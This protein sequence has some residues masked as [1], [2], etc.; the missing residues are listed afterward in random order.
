MR[1]QKRDPGK[2]KKKID[3][4]SFVISL[5]LSQPQPLTLSLPLT[6]TSL[7]RPFLLLKNS[8]S[9]APATTR[10]ALIPP[11]GDGPALVDLMLKDDAAKAAA[12][13]RATKT[14]ELSDRGACDVELLIVGGFSPLQGFMDEREYTAVVQT[15]RLPDG[16][17][18]GLPVVLDTNDDAIKEG[19]ALLLTYKGQELAVLDVSSKWTPNKPVEARQCYGTTSIEHPAVQMITMERGRYYLGGK[20]SGLALPKRAFPCASPAEVRAGLPVGEDVLAFQCRNPIHRAHY[21]LFTRALDASNV[22]KGAVCLVHPTVGPTQDDDIPGE[23]RV[24]TYEVLKEEVGNPRLRWA[25]LPYSMHMAGPR[26]AVQHMAIRKNY[27]CTH[28]IIGRDMAGCKSSL[29]GEKRKKKLLLFRISKVGFFFLSSFFSSHLQKIPIL[30]K[31]KLKNQPRRRLLHPLRGPG[32]G[33]PR[34]PGAR[35]GHR[36]LS[37]H[38]LHR[39]EGLRD[40]RRRRKRKPPPAEAVRDQV[41][42]AAAVRGGDPGVV[43]VQVGGQGAE[44]DLREEERGMR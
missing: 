37:Q 44:G 12:K 8:A 26:E 25:Y 10:T 17:L 40:G 34:R 30:E 43:C 2:K 4:A 28:F 6:S 15:M 42:A 9:A 32:H 3:D 14:V 19:D 11:H 18:F 21:E 33:P 36:P 7:N 31:Q 23:A 20:I 24:R 38:H 1:V 16:L 29:S 13:A 27:G 22:S 35:H 5:N 41:Q 39:G